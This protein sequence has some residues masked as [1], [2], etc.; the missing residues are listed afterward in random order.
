M[1]KDELKEV[2]EDEMSDLV[3]LVDDEGKTLQFYHIGTID[4]K[5]KWYACFQPAEELDGVDPDEVVIFEISGEEGNEVFLPIA[6][7]KLL[8][9]VY[10]EFMREME[11]DEPCENCNGCTKDKE[12]CKE[13]SG[14]DKTN[15]A[16]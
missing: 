14:C 9:E 12:E 11:D 10:D 2:T 8:E 1:S 7:E 6:D 15:K 3:E 5:D 4:Y 13:C 16:N